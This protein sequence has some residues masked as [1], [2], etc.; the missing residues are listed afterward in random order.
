MTI[1]KNAWTKEM[2]AALLTYAKAG[3]SG[4]H[5]AGH[6]SQKF[7]RHFS[8]SAILGRCRRQRIK[9]MR[10]KPTPAIWAIPAYAAAHKGLPFDGHAKSQCVWPSGEGPYVFAC[11]STVKEGKPYCPE[12]CKSAYRRTRELAL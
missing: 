8:R 3:Q 1:K 2:S 9:L 6:L 7:G 4:S 12:H 10:T 11:T 5:I